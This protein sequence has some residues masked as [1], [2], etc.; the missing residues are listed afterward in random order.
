MSKKEAS[1]SGR[2]SSG[3]R[4]GSFASFDELR[5]HINVQGLRAAVGVALVVVS[6]FAIVEYYVV[7]QHFW[8]LQVLRGACLSVLV[9]TLLT[10]LRHYDWACRHVDALTIAAFLSCGWYSIALMCLHDGY[11]SSFFLTL[12]FIIVGVGAVTLWPLRIAIAYIALVIVSYLAPM[13]LGFVQLRSRD[14][15]G[16]HL[17]FLMGMGLISVV[18]QQLR[19][20]IE[21]REFETSKQLRQTKA[22]LEDAFARLKEL[23]QAKTD[24]FANVSHELR[25]PLTLSLGPLESLLAKERSPADL[26]DLEALHRNQLRLLRLITQ[27]LDFAKVEATGEAAEFL[28]EDIIELVRDVVVEVQAASNEKGISLEAALPDD[29]IWVW[30]DGEK[31]EHALLN[32]LANAFKFTARGGRIV[33]RVEHDEESVRISVSDTGVGIPY[34]RQALIFDRFSQV[35]ASETREY[36]GTGIGLALVKSYVEIHG[37]TVEV[38]SAPGD[39]STFTI[40]LPLGFQHLPIGRVLPPDRVLP[41]RR[42]R[43]HHLVDFESTENLE[44]S[45]ALIGRDDRGGADA[46]APGPAPSAEAT[47]DRLRVLVVDDNADMRRY[48]ATLLRDDYALRF[49]ENGRDGLRET[50]AWDPDVVVSDVMMPIMSGS[51]MCRAIKSSGGRVARTPVILVTARA[52]EQ[53]KLRSLDQG[54]DDYLLKPFLQEELRL[55]VRNLATKRRQEQALAEAHL[56]LSA[57]H[58]RLVSDMEL[59]REFQHSLMSQPQLPRPWSAHVEFRPADTVGGDFYHLAVV[60]PDHI[61]VLIGDMVDHGVKAAVRAAVALP[62]Y[63]SLDCTLEPHEILERLNEIATTKYEDLSGSLLCAD[64]RASPSGLSLRYAQAGQMPFTFAQSGRVVVHSA[65]QGF[66]FGLSRAMSYESHEL[67]IPRGARLFLYSDG[68]YTQ[69]DK[70]GQAFRDRLK[71]VWRLTPSHPD[72]VDATRAVVTALDQFR[73]DEAQTDDLTLIGIEAEN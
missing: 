70:S 27:L 67:T 38:Q 65:A 11:G 50:Q 34:D 6:S 17:S 52:E 71:A 42:L 15:F 21:R 9:V 61:R 16:I 14:T 46:D 68:L 57:Q 18:A 28:R 47:H 54:A 22:S 49:A 66:M 26:E 72:I 58:D 8:V 41:T 1:G 53:T 69:R 62:E 3:E 4:R 43:K 35:D 44:A 40:A 33:V 31:I 23:D 5:R 73:G 32:L 13:L 60:R 7:P 19:Y 56:T 45:G 37:G 39:G 63:T 25:T 10:T 51:D 64:L 30:C 29:A 55:R 36:A 59:A 20:Q 12:V 24:F 2:R 48:V